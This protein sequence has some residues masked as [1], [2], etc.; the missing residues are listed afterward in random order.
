MYYVCMYET[1]SVCES[2]CVCFHVRVCV[3][4]C[5]N[6]CTCMYMFFFQLSG[7]DSRFCIIFFLQHR[8]SNP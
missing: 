1:E 8:L 3:Y 6:V 5:V 2:V 4:V 7:V